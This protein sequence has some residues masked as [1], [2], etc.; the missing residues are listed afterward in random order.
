MTFANPRVYCGSGKLM[1]LHQLPHAQAETLALA[2]VSTA[3]ARLE[4]LARRFPSTLLDYSDASLRTLI[5]DANEQFTLAEQP[6]S[7]PLPM[8]CEDDHHSGYLELSNDSLWLV[9]ALSLYLGDLL[10]SRDPN[11]LHWGVYCSERPTHPWHH[12]PAVL[13]YRWP[14]STFEDLS[15]LAVKAVKGHP[16]DPHKVVAAIN[17][18]LTVFRRRTS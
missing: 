12:H 1:Y 6:S 8:W 7:G 16:E 17:F 2:W 5:R 13:G 3:P 4:W 10:I 15:T 9:D 14:Y 18:Y 11:V